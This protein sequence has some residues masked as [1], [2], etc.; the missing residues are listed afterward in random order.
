MVQNAGYILENRQSGRGE[1]LGIGV[2]NLRYGLYF[3]ENG[4]KFRV[5][6]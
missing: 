6:L 1:W 2:K 3:R 4:V 5:T